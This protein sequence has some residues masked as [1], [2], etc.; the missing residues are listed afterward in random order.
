MSLIPGQGIKIPHDAGQL[1]QLSLHTT[2]KTQLNQ[3]NIFKKILQSF[4][5]LG[6]IF[7]VCVS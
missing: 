4:R 7:L 1:S 3:I 2:R 6:H 5:A